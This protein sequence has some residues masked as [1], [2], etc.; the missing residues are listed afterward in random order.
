MVLDK[1]HL[2]EEGLSKIKELAK[3][4]NQNAFHGGEEDKD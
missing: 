4:V 3:I 2:T 1:V